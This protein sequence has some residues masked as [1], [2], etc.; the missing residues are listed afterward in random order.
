MLGGAIRADY[1]KTA[2]QF[3]RN[4][5]LKK[6]QDLI[7]ADGK[8]SSGNVVINWKI[9]GLKSR[10]VTANDAVAFSQ[11]KQNP[12]GEFKGEFVHLVLE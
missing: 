8:S 4:W 6:A 5:A 2:K 1:S 12:I 10:T 9:Y 3:T 11:E 7:K